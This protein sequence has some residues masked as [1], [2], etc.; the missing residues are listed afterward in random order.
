LPGVTNPTFADGLAWY[1]VDD[2]LMHDTLDYFE[3]DPVE[4]KISPG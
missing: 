4:K 3:F 2:G 1:E